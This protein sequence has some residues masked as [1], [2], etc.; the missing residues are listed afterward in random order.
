ML[1]ITMGAYEEK[2]E[3]TEERERRKEVKREE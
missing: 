1:I 2:D 3:E